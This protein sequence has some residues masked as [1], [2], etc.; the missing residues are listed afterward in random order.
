MSKHSQN[1]AEVEIENYGGRKPRKP[2]E[3]P[4]QENRPMTQAELNAYNASHVTTSEKK[5]NDFVAHMERQ[6]LLGMIGHAVDYEPKV[7]FRNLSEGK[8]ELETPKIEMRQMS[9]VFA[10]LEAIQAKAGAKKKTVYRYVVRPAYRVGK[11]G[12][13]YTVLHSASLK[14]LLLVNESYEVVGYLAEN[15]SSTTL[16]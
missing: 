5:A 3:Q 13:I 12:P 10:D 6:G 9:A 15:E 14:K 1:V 16:D 4:Q 2:R 8:S 11:S 7:G